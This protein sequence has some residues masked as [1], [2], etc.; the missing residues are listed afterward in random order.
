MSL[1]YG[2]QLTEKVYLVP[3]KGSQSFV[4]RMS[5]QVSERWKFSFS[6][7]F[8]ESGERL[9]TIQDLVTVKTQSFSGGLEFP[10]TQRVSGEVSYT[11]EDREG[12]YTRTGGA[13]NLI[14][15]W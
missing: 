13:F 14:Y 11:Y 4:S 12:G 6:A 8:G 15:R 7:S 3:R 5:W 10:L 2:L 1:P 9:E